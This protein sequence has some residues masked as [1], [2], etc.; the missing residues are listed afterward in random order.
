MSLITLDYR[1]EAG[2]LPDSA[3]AVKVAAVKL[4]MGELEMLGMTVFSDATV[5]ESPGIVKRTIVLATTSQGEE[6]FPSVEAKKA[7]T[8]NL[9][10]LTLGAKT[11][12]AFSAAEPVVT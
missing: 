6:R 4:F 8:R 1:V 5:V 10:G 11:P 2:A 3:L 7:A 12:G 9:Y